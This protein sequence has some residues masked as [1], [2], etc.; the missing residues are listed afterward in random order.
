MTKLLEQAVAKARAL[1]EAR[2]N[3]IARL[4]LSEIEAKQMRGSGHSILDIAPV[5]LGSVIC[6]PEADDL[7]GEMLEDRR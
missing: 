2:Q 5:S 7:L 4:V 1:P 3:A 6:L